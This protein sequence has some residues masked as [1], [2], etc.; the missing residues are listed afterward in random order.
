MKKINLLILIITIVT[1]CNLKETI[2]KLGKISAEL[3]KEFK[4]SEINST[5]HFG[6]EDD[7]NYF[8]ISFYN[9]DLTE[10]THSEL[11]ELANKIND[12][13]VKKY[14]EYNDLDFLEVR[15]TKSD[16]TNADSF[17]N[18]KFK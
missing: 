6:T 4:H 16:E 8:Q 2:Q 5:Y 14:P 10:K 9:Y 1:S 12:F 13:F 15:F 3:E 7:D 17:V 18:F 11:E